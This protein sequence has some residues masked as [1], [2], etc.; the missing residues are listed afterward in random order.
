M[1]D[2]P[3]KI[4]FNLTE[5]DVDAFEGVSDTHKYFCFAAIVWQKYWDED[6]FG[7][8]KREAA[9]ADLRKRYF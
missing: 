6:S 9:L 1:N 2:E 8:T 7:Y 3:E 5:D 4:I